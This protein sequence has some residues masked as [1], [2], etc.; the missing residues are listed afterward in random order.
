[1]DGSGIRYVKHNRPLFKTGKREEAKKM[2]LNFFAENEGK[3]NGFKGHLI[4][5]S[6]TDDREEVVLTFWSSK[7]DMDSFY[8]S[9]SFASFVAKGKELFD[10]PPER[11]DMTVVEFNIG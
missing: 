6:I 3:V 4:L 1:M 8:N 10:S 9:E 11:K 7:E 5:D 2:L